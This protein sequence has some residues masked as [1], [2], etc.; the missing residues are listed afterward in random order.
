MDTI[1]KKTGLTFGYILA[2]Y[3]II[4]NLIIFFSDYTLF[5]KPYLGIVNMI[6]VLILGILCIWIAKRRSGNLITTKQG[7]TAFFIMIIVGLLVNYLLQFTLF[8]FVNP[9]A[10]EVNNQLMVT[11]AESI[12]KQMNVPDEEITKQIEFMRN[13]PN[14]N[15]SL[16]NMLFSFA[17]SILGASIAGLLIALTFRNKTEF[18][19]PKAQ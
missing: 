5:A 3:Y 14:D 18:S 2:S 9:E 6:F 16:K 4:V 13:N 17:Q 11:M 8:N 12:A 7:F 19:T 10:K 1:S 15:F